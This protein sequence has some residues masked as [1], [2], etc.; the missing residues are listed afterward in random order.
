MVTFEDNLRNFVIPY[1]EKQELVFHPRKTAMY[2]P[3]I[4]H[5]TCRVDKDITCFIA[6]CVRNNLYCTYLT[7]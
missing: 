6:E 4:S 5:Y 7:D 2:V 3:N 1:P